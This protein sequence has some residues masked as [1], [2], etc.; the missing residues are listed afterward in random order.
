MSNV[1]TI[2]ED[3]R[4]ICYSVGGCC[5]QGNVVVGDEAFMYTIRTLLEVTAQQTNETVIEKH[6]ARFVCNTQRLL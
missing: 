6:C 3:C 4:T 5:T 1:H 2:R